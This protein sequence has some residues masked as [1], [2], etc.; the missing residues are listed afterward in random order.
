MYIYIYTHVCANLPTIIKV[1]CGGYFSL[2]ARC[3]N[4]RWGSLEGCGLTWVRPQEPSQ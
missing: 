1:R 2:V 4:C 3:D